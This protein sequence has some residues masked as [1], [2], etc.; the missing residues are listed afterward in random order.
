MS[1]SKILS[2]T[3]ETT[4]F[5]TINY[6]ANELTLEDSSII[7]IYFRQVKQKCCRN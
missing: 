4:L 3:L 5:L 7:F 1:E 6:P 2:R